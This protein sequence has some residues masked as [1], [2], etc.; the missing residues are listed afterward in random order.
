MSLDFERISLLMNIIVEC[1]KHG[2]LYHAIA[3]EAQAELNKITEGLREEKGLTK[4]RTVQPAEGGP[5]RRKDP[6]VTDDVP[7]ARPSASLERKV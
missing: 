6:P 2:P 5:V 7:K 4:Q 1:G 3:G